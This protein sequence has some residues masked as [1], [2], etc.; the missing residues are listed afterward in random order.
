VK[1]LRKRSSGTGATRIFFAADIHG[2]EQTFRKFVNAARFYGADALVFGGDLTGKALVPIV[3]QGGGTYLGGL[4]GEAR[5]IE[6]AAELRHLQRRAENAGLYWTVLEPDEYAG[7]RDD[8]AAREALFVRLARERLSTWVAFAEDRLSGSH[9]RCFLTGGNDD[10]PA[11]LPVL[12][13][14]PGD[15]VV[16][17]EHRVVELDAVHSMITVGYST[18]TPWDTPREA[19]EEVIAGAIEASVATVADPS[20][21][22]FNLHVPPLRSGLDRC[23]ALDTS[24][25]PPTPLK[26]GGQPVWTAGGSEAVDDAIRRHQPVLGLHGH[27]HES[28]GRARVGRTA[29]FNPGSEYGQGTLRGMLVGI[30]DGRVTGYQATAG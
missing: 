18:P 11:V 21:C 15:R 10:S 19:S 12:E 3:S 23:P 9:V 13:E 6:D 14:H 27:I 1:L 5:L 26:R 16:A 17:C 24:T 25:D 30:A 28:P 29:C 7:L 8:A 20:R 2:S 22:V 4:P